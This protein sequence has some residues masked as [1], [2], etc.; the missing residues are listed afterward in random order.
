MLLLFFFHQQPDDVSKRQETLKNELEQELRT[1]FK[2]V[3][4]TFEGEP[5][6][7]FK[8]V[9]PVNLANEE[10]DE[11]PFDNEPTSTA[12]QINPSTSPLT[13][14]NGRVFVPPSS[15]AVFP[16]SQPILPSK[17]ATMSASTKRPEAEKSSNTRKISGLFKR[18]SMEIP[19]GLSQ[20]SF[21]LPSPL[22]SKR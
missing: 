7:V 14:M 3:R 20:G 21:G 18:R 1:P 4:P 17:F 6:D 16:M 11:T 12:T 5:D 8:G 10:F 15:S 13:G 9:Q 22:F 19:G 2:P